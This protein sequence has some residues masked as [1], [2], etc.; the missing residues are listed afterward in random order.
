[1]RRFTTY[2]S[3]IALLGMSVLSPS[4]H[5]VDVGDANGDHRV[6]IQD[7]Q[8]VIAEILQGSRSNHDGDVN[9]DGRVDVLDFQVVLH[10]A[11]Q[12]RAQQEWPP[13]DAKS[14]KA[15]P[16]ARTRSLT[17]VENRAVVVRANLENSG[18]SSSV[19]SDPLVIFS[20]KTERYFFNLTAH[21][22]PLRV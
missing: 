16:T 13:A 4:R 3:I 15:V 12:A 1:M 22:P 6:N 19:S 8:I 11:T 9:G 17:S 14:D 2:L 5:E 7:V 21:A 20:P 10:R 18:V